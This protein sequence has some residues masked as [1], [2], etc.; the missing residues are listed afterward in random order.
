MTPPPTP[1]SPET[2]PA[3]NE[4]TMPGP[5]VPDPIA[6]L[7]PVGRL[8]VAGHEPSALGVLVRHRR[9]RR[10]PLA[11]HLHGN[12]Q[13]QRAEQAGQDVRV[14]EAR[15][16]PARDASGH[17]RDEQQERQAPIDEAAVEVVR[18]RSGRRGDDP[19]QARRDGRL[20][21]DAQQQ[22][23]RRHDDQAAADADQ[24]TE[25]AGADRDEE[26]DEGKAHLDAASHA[27]TRSA[28]RCGGK[29]G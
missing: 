4:A 26:R 23:Q 25:P 15:H 21:V 7:G 11:E 22:R 8:D 24:A 29:H 5:R 6:D 12:Q 27:T 17:R 3:A 20:D 14:E 2:L 18:R 19:H 16:G 13:Q 10:C 28:S 1:S 9:R